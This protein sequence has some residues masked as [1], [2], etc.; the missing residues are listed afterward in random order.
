[1]YRGRHSSILCA[2]LICEKYEFDF[3]FSARADA[4][5]CSSAPPRWCN[6]MMMMTRLCDGVFVAGGWG[7]SKRG[8][9]GANAGA[10]P[11]HFAIMRI[12][13][14][15]RWWHQ[16]RNARGLVEGGTVGWGT[17]KRLLGLC[18]CMGGT[19]TH[20]HIHG[21]AFLKSR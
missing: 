19:Q 18:L 2:D 7:I 12:E 3:S 14:A 6:V 4:N 17:K 8:R 10:A 9:A 13:D 21:I 1:M 5:T 15:E 16:E 20:T 11:T